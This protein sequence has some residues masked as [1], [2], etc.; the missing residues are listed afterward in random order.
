[1]GGK[2]SATLDKPVIQSFSAWIG[3]FGFFIGL[4]A[5]LI[6][7][8]LLGKSVDDFNAGISSLGSG[9]PQLIASSGNGFT[10]IWVAYAFYA[11]PVI[12]SMTKI[13]VTQTKA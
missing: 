7:R 8:M 10:M 1:M 2:I 11:V 5:F 13:N 4:T 9:A 6:L 12:A 3:F